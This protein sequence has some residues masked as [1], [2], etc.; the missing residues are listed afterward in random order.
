MQARLGWLKPPKGARP[1]ESSFL[2]Y[3]SNDICTQMLETHK[4]ALTSH[5]L[6][7]TYLVIRYE[8]LV[9][10]FD[11]Q[12]TRLMQFVDEP[13]TPQLLEGAMK[14]L[15]T[16]M[17]AVANRKN[18]VTEAEVRGTMEG[19]AACRTLIGMFG[20]DKMPSRPSDHDSPAGQKPV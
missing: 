14:V 10:D 3:H 5:E 6:G 9:D 2:S 16:D 11:T 8:D 7:K 15:N 1:G 19:V 13:I 4:V 17:I 18:V 12:V 20:Y